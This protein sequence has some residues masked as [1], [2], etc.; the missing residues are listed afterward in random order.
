MLQT[1]CDAPESMQ[2]QLYGLGTDG[3]SAWWGS[4][5]SLFLCMDMHRTKPDMRKLH[6]AS[7]R[8]QL[9]RH[10]EAAQLKQMPLA[11]V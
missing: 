4:Q 11:A 7:R 3:L 10:P 2:C 9:M 6:A 1:L 8:Q 5:H